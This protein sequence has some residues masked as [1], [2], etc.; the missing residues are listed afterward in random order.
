MKHIP[1]QY[2]VNNI[3]NLEIQLVK[4]SAELEY[5]KA[6]LYLDNLAHTQETV[7]VD[8]LAKHYGIETKM[9]FDVDAFRNTNTGYSSCI[10]I[11][12]RAIST[13]KSNAD[14]KKNPSW[15]NQALKSAAIVD[16]YAK[17]NY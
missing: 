8:Y 11:V 6:W 2:T 13:Y 7:L 10:N 9:A 15:A 17:N 16:N 3:E 4:I 14:T 1:D 12:K 5:N